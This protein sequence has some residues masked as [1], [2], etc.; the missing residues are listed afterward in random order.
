V[1]LPCAREPG[2][3]VCMPGGVI[4]TPAS[5]FFAHRELPLLDEVFIRLPGQN[6]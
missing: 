3:P 5:S 1:Q 6:Q 4:S 2:P